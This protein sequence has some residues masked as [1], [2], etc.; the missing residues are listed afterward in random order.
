V[1]GATTTADPLA[2]VPTRRPVRRF[3]WVAGVIAALSFAAWGLGLA[4]PRL[5]GAVTTYS[6]N[7]RTGRATV[8]VDLEN[9]GPLPVELRSV[10]VPDAPV[11]ML[12]FRARHRTLRGGQGTPLVIQLRVD[13]ARVRRSESGFLRRDP[14]LVTVRTPSGLRR[15]REAGLLDQDFYRPC[16]P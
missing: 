14:V 10:T 2:F 6:L 12:G 1:T 16:V 15:A 3:V 7:L 8:E 13:C 4:A 5:D 9:E 11:T